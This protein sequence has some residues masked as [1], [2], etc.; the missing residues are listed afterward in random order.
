MNHLKSIVRMPHGGAAGGGSQQAG[1][2]MELVSST[3]A[4][5]LFAGWPNYQS[6]HHIVESPGAS[7]GAR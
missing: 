5:A 2:E 7:N 6:S 1:F 3:G 4:N